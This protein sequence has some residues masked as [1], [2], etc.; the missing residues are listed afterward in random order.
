MKRQFESY[1]F[2]NF[3]KGNTAVVVDKLKAEIHGD[4]ICYPG[5]DVQTFSARKAQLKKLGVKEVYFEGDSKVGNL[6]VIGKGCVSVV[7]K[8]RIKG[9]DKIVA[10]KCRRT[11]ANRDNMQRDYEL[12]KYANSFGVGPKAI[13][14]S[15]DFFAMEFIY[16]LKIGKWYEKL[17]T[18][19]SKKFLRRLIR[20]SLTQ[21]LLLDL[22]S[23]DHGEL[24][25][26]SK[27]IMIR[28][29]E[30]SG[31][32]IPKTVII[33]Y[34]SAGRERKVSN[35][36]SVAQF[37]FLSGYK[38]KKVQKILGFRYNKKKLILLL[39]E[40]KNEPEPEKLEQILSYV[41]C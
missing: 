31:S 10:L 34:E 38:S 12:Q 30:E 25:N 17:R 23:L 15:D 19:S 5:K 21:C 36:T 26:P 37:Y 16:G 9:Q 22:H 33:D 8:A 18:R 32:L 4:V 7:L 14:A 20:D 6:G 2:E 28:R 41:R 3:E 1:C 29:D 27:H 13:A 24:S 39:K 11:D 40:Y 35:V